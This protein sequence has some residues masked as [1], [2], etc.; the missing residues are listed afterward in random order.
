MNSA[1]QNCNRCETP[2]EQGDLRCSIC[3]QVSPAD[4]QVNELLTIQVMRCQGCGA[5]TAYDIEHQAPSCSFC[6]S[7]MEV[8][9][10]EDPQE[11]TG[12]YLPF[13]IDQDEARRAMRHWLGSLGWFRPSDLKTAAR[14]EQLKPLWWVGWVFDAESFVSW[15]ADSNQ[16]SRRSAW[17]PYAGQVDMTFDDMLVSASRGLS[18]AEASAIGPGCDLST[19]RDEPEGANNASIEQFDLQRSQA[20][21]QIINAIQELAADR[22]EAQHVPGSRFRKVR[23]SVVLRKLITRRVSLP[24]WVLAYRYKGS[25]Y[26]MVICGQDA[27]RVTGSAP[28]SIARIV[29]VAGMAIAAAAMLIAAVASS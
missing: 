21:Q 24:A 26:R 25:L 19:I 8:E 9:T 27:T 4:R 11:Q 20:R 15:T 5:A 6:D 2:L 12:G 29:L 10:L 1:I 3:G 16:S 7:V 28:Y 22:V 18:G 17:A 23:V 14:L 13:T